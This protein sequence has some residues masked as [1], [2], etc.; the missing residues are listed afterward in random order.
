MPGQKLPHVILNPAHEPLYSLIARSLVDALPE[1]LRQRITE[2]ELVRAAGDAFSTFYVGWPVVRRRPVNSALLEVLRRAV[3][4]I[5]GT[6]EFRKAHQQTAYSA[7]KS[8][9]Y[10]V[11]LLYNV[12][13]RVAQLPDPS[14][15]P[16]HVLDYVARNAANALRVR[17]RDDELARIASEL[18]ELAKLLEQNKRGSSSQQGQQSSQQSQ[19]Q[20]QQGQQHGQQPQQNQQH[21]GGGVGGREAG[22]QPGTLST[23]AKIAVLAVS[24]RDVEQILILGGEIEA[25]F[26]FFR[27]QRREARRGEPNGYSITS[28]P[29]KALPREHALPSELWYA[30]LVSGSWLKRRYVQEKLGMLIVAIDKSGSMAGE[31]TVWA[32]SVAYALVKLALKRRQPVAAMLFDQTV[33]GPFTEP[34]EIIQLILD[35]VS[36][37][38]TCIDCVLRRALQVLDEHRDRANTIVIITDGQD[39]VTTPPSELTK[40]NARL[41]AVMIQGYNASL[42]H[43]ARV[44]GGQYMRA[45]LSSDGALKVVDAAL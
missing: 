44:S 17:C 16:Q 12:V 14:R 30:K 33:W 40:R 6:E 19:G 11:A 7:P 9:A 38:G 29:A 31:K 42:E 32:R 24:S 5:S 2:E 10:G 35:T 26:R 39:T 21:H 36:N 27:G 18:E 23:L 22:D 43:L 3:N 8:L 13:W 28:N 37:G 15:A 45:E 1:H 34:S 25:R 20:Q 41:V 4:Y